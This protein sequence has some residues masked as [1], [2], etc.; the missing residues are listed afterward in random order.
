MSATVT[1]VGSN[2]MVS[3]SDDAI[4]QVLFALAPKDLVAFKRTTSRAAVLARS[5]PWAL[6]MVHQ[7][8]AFAPSAQLIQVAWR[9][10]LCRTW[11]AVFD[12]PGVTHFTRARMGD[13]FS[14]V[15]GPV[16]SDHPDHC[17]LVTRLGASCSTL[18]MSLGI[19]PSLMTDGLLPVYWMYHPNGSILNN[20]TGHGDNWDDINDIKYFYDENTGVVK[21]CLPRHVVWESRGW[22]LFYW[23]FQQ[24]PYNL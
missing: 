12:G 6:Y 21:T 20:M 10:K 5:L 13:I 23:A 17:R 7:C 11:L 16:L 24:L 1:E 3:L 8:G 18:E 22:L 4:M 9:K 2:P 14:A 15:F 19:Q